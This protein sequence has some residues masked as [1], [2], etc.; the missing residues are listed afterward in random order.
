MCVCVWLQMYLR[1]GQLERDRA[2]TF[3]DLYDS[4]RLLQSLFMESGQVKIPMATYINTLKY[5][6]FKVDI[7]ILII[8]TYMSVKFH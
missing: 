4:M 8:T 7:H 5:D 6:T 2:I 3:I 1:L